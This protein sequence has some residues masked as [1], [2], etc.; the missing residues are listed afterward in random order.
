MSNWSYS[1][2]P[3]PQP[4]P[5]RIQTWSVDLHHSS[6]QCQ[7]LNLLSEARN[8]ICILMDASQFR[9]HWAMTGT[10]R[11]TV[12]NSD[13][14]LVWCKRCLLGRGR[15]GWGSV[16]AVA[17]HLGI[18]TSS[19][20]GNPVGYELVIGKELHW[21]C[22]LV[23]TDILFRLFIFSHPT[24]YGTPGPG[25]RSEAQSR[26]KPHLWQCRFPN[27]LLQAGDWTCVPVLPRCRWSCGAT[28]GTPTR[29]FT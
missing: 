14:L 23:A 10:P 19:L 9:L 26:P 27:P 29:D 3:Q 5:H 15:F 6:G 20:V 8:R 4:Q 22:R 11:H 1:C 7:I 18:L 16:A 17:C 21:C 12:L 28:A 25:I 2:Q 13:N 24:A